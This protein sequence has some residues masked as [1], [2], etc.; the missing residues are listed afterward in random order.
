VLC[1]LYSQKLP[2]FNTHS[3]IKSATIMG[4]LIDVRWIGQTAI[5][6]DRCPALS[7]SVRCPTLQNRLVIRW[8][9]AFAPL[10]HVTQCF[11]ADLTGAPLIKRSDLFTAFK[12]LLPTIF[13]P[14]G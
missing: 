3:L 13:T 6:N 14:S 8:R 11:R 12:R 2:S 4:D 1:D 5:E 7:R 10:V 9:T